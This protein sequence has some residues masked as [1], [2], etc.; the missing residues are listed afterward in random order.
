[1]PPE[2]CV[3]CGAKWE[4]I[5]GGLCQVC[6]S[7]DRLSAVIWGPEVPAGAEHLIVQRLRLWIGEAQDLG[8]L[9]R[10]VAPNP[11]QGPS[12]VG[13]GGQPRGV[14][15]TEVPLPPEGL[16]PPAPPEER[17]EAAEP[18]GHGSKEEWKKHPKLKELH[19]HQGDRLKRRRKKRQE[20]VISKKVKEGS[21]KISKWTKSRE[22]ASQP[23]SQSSSTCWGG[24][25]HLERARGSE[26]EEG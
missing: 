1:M 20:P 25:V 24:K 22:V 8:E 11:N 18:R 7:V 9:T 6:W 19:R 2:R 23:S 15:P 10:G 17:G 14:G 16:A 13:T 21:P 12:S 3:P 5:G 26:G 4:V